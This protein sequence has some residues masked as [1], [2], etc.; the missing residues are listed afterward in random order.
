MLR[1]IE[2]WGP[3]PY[4]WATAGYKGAIATGRTICGILF[5]G[6]VFLGNL[7]GMNATHAPEV[8]DEMRNRAIESVHDLFQGFI[9]QFGD[10]DCRT[11]TGCDWSKKEDSE[12]YYKEEVYKGTCYR[13]FE[14]VLAGCL[15]RMASTDPVRQDS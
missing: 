3:L 13:F 1:E 8:K 4:Q 2:G 14:Y 9:E 11:L 10:T 6:S 15:D 12:R 5:G 7:S